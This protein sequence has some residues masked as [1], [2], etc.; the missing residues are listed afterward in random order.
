MTTYNATDLLSKPLAGSIENAGVYMGS[1]SP[2]SNTATGDV[3][4]PMKLPAGFKFCALLVNVRTAFA[5]TAPAK[6]GI[7]HIDGSTPPQAN[8]DSLV[9]AS[10]DTSHASTGVKTLM[11][12]N[13]P[14]I[15]QRDAWL[16]V[17]FGTIATAATGVADYVAMGEILGT[18]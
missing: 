16:Q 2:G 11:P 13:G 12:Q 15:L 14:F 9:V 3:L 8:P 18:T 10:T 5:S 17:V 6:I 1:V 7:A 4:Q